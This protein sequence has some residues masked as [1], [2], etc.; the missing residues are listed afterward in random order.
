MM[1]EKMNE[2]FNVTVVCEHHFDQAEVIFL[3]IA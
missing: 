3:V 2:A 1:V